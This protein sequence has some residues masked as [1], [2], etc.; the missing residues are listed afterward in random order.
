MITNKL[1]RECLSAVSE[2]TKTEFEM[3]FRIAERVADILHQKGLTQRDLASML[4]KRE[5]E[6]SK[7]MTGRH[8]FTISTIARITAALGEDIITITPHSQKYVF[9]EEPSKHYVADNHTQP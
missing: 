6:V 5:S 7:W 3:S 4:G 1:F 9:P 2:E 8:N